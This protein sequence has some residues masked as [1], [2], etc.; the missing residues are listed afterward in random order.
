EPE[1]P[2]EPELD[3][4][5][6][7]SGVPLE[8]PSRPEPLD[9]LPLPS[10]PV[11]VVCTTAVES[12][13]PSLRDVLW[14]PL[15]SPDPEPLEV[16]ARE[17]SPRPREC[18]SSEPTSRPARSSRG[19]TAVAGPAVRGNRTRVS[20]RGCVCVPGGRC[21]GWDTSPPPTSASAPTPT[22]AALLTADTRCA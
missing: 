18:S 12:F 9:V 20:W 13:E 10:L 4:P 15:R 6:L 8:E 2:S 3:V 16:D 14:P 21:V 22:T 19:A 11:V 1:P 7:P 17:P 5:E